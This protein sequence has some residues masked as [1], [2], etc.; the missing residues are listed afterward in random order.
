MRISK[1]ECRTGFNNSEF[2]PPEIDIRGHKVLV[3]ATG[4][5]AWQ[6][7]LVA[8]FLEKKGYEVYLSSTSRSP[9]EPK[10]AIKAKHELQD[11]YGQG[12]DMFAYNIEPEHYDH[13]IICSETDGSLFD[14][15]FL[16]D[17]KTQANCV[18]VLHCE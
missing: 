6:P 4:E 10:F 17:L 8:S 9:V 5:Y 7:Y 11:N 3:L 13:I 14:S 16:Q 12:I 15:H 1:N 2:T 18:E